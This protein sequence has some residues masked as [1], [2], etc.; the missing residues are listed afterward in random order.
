MVRWSLIFVLLLAG[1]HL[2]VQGRKTTCNC[3]PPAINDNPQDPPGKQC[4]L[5]KDDESRKICIEAVEQQKSTD[6]KE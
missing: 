4:A 5:I 2:T 1:C 6:R 3:V